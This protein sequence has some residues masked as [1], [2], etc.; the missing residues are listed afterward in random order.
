MMIRFTG[1]QRQ[2]QDTRTRVMEAVEAVGESG[3]YVQ[4]EQLRRFEGALAQIWGLPFCVGVASG[5]DA[6]EIGLRALGCKAGDKVLTTPVSAFATA[7]AILRIGAA[8]IFVDIDEYGLLDLD[9]CE[10]ALA[11]DPSIRYLAPVHLYGTAMNTHRLTEIIERFGCKVVEDCAQSVGADFAGTMTGAVGHV[12]ATSFYPT[13]NLG[14]M[15]DGGAL[16]TR[17]EAVARRAAALRDYGQ[18]AKYVHDLLG[19]NSR[20]DEIQ[21]AIMHHAWLPEMP[22]WTERRRQTARKYLAGIDNSSI[23]LVGTP[24]CSNSCWHLFPLTVKP[25]RKGAFLAH[26]TEYGVGYGEHY[27]IAIPDQKAL[28]E[29]P[30]HLLD[31]CRR[32]RLLCASEVSIPIHPYLTDDE[33]EAVI[34]ACN[35]WPG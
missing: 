7:L 6:L 8:P 35:A 21:A 26:L 4:G 9:A 27:P 25:D 29:A 34:K 28:Q 14:A 17:D 19:C 3:W 10:R 20:L 24:P 31:D 5:L 23:R 12:A 32:A 2:W 22:R 33:I 30:H 13:K 15:G 1:L 11:A 18:T 16:L